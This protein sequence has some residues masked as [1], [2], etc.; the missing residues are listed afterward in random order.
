MSQKLRRLVVSHLERKELMNAL[1]SG[2]EEPPDELGPQR[3]IR[4][5]FGRGG[6][7]FHLRGIPVVQ[8]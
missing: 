6:D 2:G 5:S 1:L 7:V 3:G 4:V 8:L